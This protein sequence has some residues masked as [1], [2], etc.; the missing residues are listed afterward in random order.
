MIVIILIVKESN[1][2][3]KY[4]KW[5]KKTYNGFIE[6]LKEQ[7]DLKYKDFNTNIINTDKKVIGNRIPLL[8]QYAKEISSGDYK[9]YLKYNN[10]NYY[11]ES[12]IHGLIIGYLNLNM[13]DTI[14]MLD[15]FVIHIDNWATNDV[16]A[17]TLKVFK[18]EPE[19]GFKYINT[20]VNSDNPWFIR[21]G[22]VLLLCHYNNLEYIDRVLSITKRVEYDHYYVKMANA[23]LIS[24]CYV[25]HKDKTLLMLKDNNLDKWTH[26]KAIQ[27]IKESRQVSK[28]D[29]EM[30]DKLKKR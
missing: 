12:T 24:M 8:R 21:F 7:V 14:K 3:L 30:V 22:L 18:K 4:Y 23:W 29:K 10:H 9:D 25:K 20:L 17:S 11:E 26:N 2:I 15:E 16:V 13:Q 19:L 1:M 27:K 28:E 6:H 5:N